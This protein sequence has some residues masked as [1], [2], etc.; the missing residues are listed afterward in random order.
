MEFL[1]EE[2]GDNY[3]YLYQVKAMAKESGFE[4]YAKV[5]WRKGTFVANTGRKAKNTED[6]LFFSKGRARDMRPDA[7]KD[8]AEPEIKHY[9]SGAKGMLPTAFDIQP[10]SK[11]ERIHQSE[12][13]VELLKQILMFIPNGADR[14]AIYVQHLVPG[15]RSGNCTRSV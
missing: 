2:N 6:I 9:M 8:K 7:K 14:E 4:Y 13:P 3:E 1:P 10:I 12:K 11:V 5:A 15:G